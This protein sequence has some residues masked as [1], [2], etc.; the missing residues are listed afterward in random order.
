VARQVPEKVR[1][2]RNRRVLE[3]KE[4]LFGSAEFLFSVYEIERTD[5]TEEGTVPVYLSPHC[6]PCDECDDDTAPVQEVSHLEGT[7]TA[8]MKSC[9]IQIFEYFF[10]AVFSVN[11]IFFAE[12]YR[13]AILFLQLFVSRT[14]IFI[15]FYAPWGKGLSESYRLS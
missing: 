15:V 13:M 14:T 4:S 12:K 6:R 2:A 8:G 11:A 3:R 9:S 10:R 5:T 7:K 1:C